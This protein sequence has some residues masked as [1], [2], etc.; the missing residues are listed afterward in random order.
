[1]LGGIKISQICEEPH[2]VHVVC[3]LRWGFIN[4]VQTKDKCNSVFFPIKVLSHNCVVCA[5][6]NVMFL[7]KVGRSMTP[8][9]S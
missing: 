8:N 2:S 7:S 3:R 6:T 9:G 5:A 4:A 1:M